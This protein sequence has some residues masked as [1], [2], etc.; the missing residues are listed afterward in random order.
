MLPNLIL[1]DTPRTEPQWLT[2]HYGIERNQDLLVLQLNIINILSL[3][4]ARTP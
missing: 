1:R 2:T 3:T 4:L